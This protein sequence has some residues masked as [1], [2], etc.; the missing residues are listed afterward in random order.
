MVE[1]MKKIFF[2]FLYTIYLGA[3]TFSVTSTANSGPGTYSAAIL[4]VNDAVSGDQT[5]SFEVNPI[6]TANVN[7]LTYTAGNI[8]FVSSELDTERTINANSY[9]ALAVA[10]DVHVMISGEIL[11]NDSQIFIAGTVSIDGNESLD[12]VLGMYLSENG[13]IEFNNTTTITGPCV[14]DGEGL[15][16]I[17]V[18]DDYETTFLEVISGTGPLM[19]MGSG[20][21][22]LVGTNTYTSGTQLLTGQITAEN[23]SA[24]G[25]GSIYVGDGTIVSMQN[26]VEITNNILISGLSTVNVPVGTGTI[27][28]I[29][30]SGGTL[31][32]TGSGVLVLTA[33]NSYHG[34]TI[35]MIGAIQVGNSEALGDGT[36]SMGDDT[37][38]IFNE[39]MIID[40]DVI[41]TGRHV[42]QLLCSEIC[43]KGDIYNEGYV[44]KTGSGDL[45]LDG[46][47]YGS[48][49]IYVTNGRLILSQKEDVA[50]VI[51]TGG[52]LSG[53]S[54][55]SRRN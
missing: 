32:K 48:G 18:E 29:I 53:I 15:K 26:G 21:L 17:I 20:I 36:L 19:K 3:E 9:L 41:L 14:L 34:G 24:F 28:G 4:A 31:Q 8:F 1:T 2:S 27:S 50:I 30:G 25:E 42:W 43:M 46:D 45:I 51:E 49:K 11:L 37:A 40:N 39:S 7:A 47:V 23:N 16:A 5:I 33:T 52:I 6:L 22:V 44:Q 12:G 35:L 13:S 38:L 54:R 10:N 55:Y